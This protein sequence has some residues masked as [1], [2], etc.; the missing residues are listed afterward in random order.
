MDPVQGHSIEIASELKNLNRICN[1]IRRLS[2]TPRAQSLFA[3]PSS[4]P[5]ITGIPLRVAG[6]P[7]LSIE[8]KVVSNLSSGEAKTNETTFEF[9][10]PFRVPATCNLVNGRPWTIYELFRDQKYL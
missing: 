10:D 6:S 2:Q 8:Q 4:L 9:M 1:S 7:R 3:V 5:L